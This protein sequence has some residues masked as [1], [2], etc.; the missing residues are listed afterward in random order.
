[1]FP[2]DRMLI[3]SSR[4]YF[5]LLSPAPRGVLGRSPGLASG[6][7]NDGDDPDSNCL[8]RASSSARR[9]TSWAI[10]ASEDAVLCV[11]LR[12]STLISRGS[13]E[14]DLRGSDPATDPSPG[15]NIRIQSKGVAKGGMALP[16]WRLSS[17][18]RESLMNTRR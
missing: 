7:G 9:S 15:K 10:V 4:T 16:A 6:P 8:R 14:I 2:E 1:M 3:V 13:F 12:A 17:V 11:T 5:E 18:A